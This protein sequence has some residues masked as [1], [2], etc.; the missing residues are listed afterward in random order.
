MAW[1]FLTGGSCLP[2]EH[3]WSI[4]FEDDKNQVGRDDEAA[5]FW[6]T[7]TDINPDHILFFGRKDNFWE[8]GD[9]GPCG[10]CSERF[11]LD[12]GP[13]AAAT[14]RVCRGTCCANGDCRRFIELWNLV[15]IQYNRSK[16]RASSRRCLRHVDTGMGFERIVGVLQGTQS[17]YDTDLFTPIIAATQKLL[18]ESGVQRDVSR[19]GGFRS[20]GCPIT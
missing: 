10:P 3:L 5:G 8:M 14:S 13:G 6:K 11:T 15:F 19:T 16:P 4:V 20:G 1:V 17:N 2:K 7:E 9:T 18:A 12:L